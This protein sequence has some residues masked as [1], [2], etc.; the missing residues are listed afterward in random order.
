MKLPEKLKI[1]KIFKN[2]EICE[3]AKR[4]EE[5]WREEV[6][7]ECKKKYIAK[8]Y[9]KKWKRKRKRQGNRGKYWKE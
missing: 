8:V 5:K 7:K 3:N 6:D 1:R 4:E 9:F 2:A